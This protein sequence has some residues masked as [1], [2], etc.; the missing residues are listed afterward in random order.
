VQ[1]RVQQPSECV[2]VEITWAGGYRTEHAL[3]RPVSRYEQLSGYT[4]LLQR[5]EQLR[6]QKQTLA[7]IAEQLNEEGYRPPKR[8]ARF[9]GGMIARLL[10]KQGRSGPRPRAIASGE[11]LGEEEWL[12]SDLARELSMPTATLQRWRRV[13]WVQARKL[14][15]AGGHWAIW[16]D[17]EERERMRR[18][19]KQPRGWSEEPVLKAL[20]TPKKRPEK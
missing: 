5:I 12:L 18:L 2:H 6:E 19:R 4:E 20:T 9:N 14:P 11:L 7:Q 15:V 13:G 1:V 17:A 16:A 10:S 3:R 8:C